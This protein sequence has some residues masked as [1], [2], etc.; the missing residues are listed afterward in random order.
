MISLTPIIALTNGTLDYAPYIF[1]GDIRA[2]VP[3]GSGQTIV[4]QVRDVLGLC[5]LYADNKFFCPSR[6][7]RDL[8]TVVSWD[9]NRFRPRGYFDDGSVWEPYGLIECKL[10][11]QKKPE[12]TLYI[13]DGPHGLVY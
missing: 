7:N 9:Y 4:D 1:G 11:C 13:G 12:N 3:E 8:K 6:Q 10:H 5:A 2:T